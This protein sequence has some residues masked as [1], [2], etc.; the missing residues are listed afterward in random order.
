MLG[1]FSSEWVK[2][3]RRAMLLWGL[4][5][6]LFFALLA[7]IFTIERAVRTPQL[8]GGGHGVR[9]TFAVLEQPDGLTHGIVDI[10]GL[11]G[12]VALCLFAGAFATEYS[13]GTMR[14]LLV[15]E[16]RRSRLLAG[17]FLALAAFIT[18]AVVLEIVVSSAVAFALAPGRGISTAAWTSSAGL[19]DLGQATLHVF[20][21]SVGYGLLGAAFGILLRSPGVAIGTAVAYILPGEAIIVGAIWGNG[22]R[23]LPGQLLDALAHGGNDNSSY[24]HALVVLA[25][26]MAA[27][28]AGSLWLFRRRDA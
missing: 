5:G 22:D 27:L 18:I 26:Y 7:T 13:Q 2:L 10:S 11:I 15:R 4:G 6:G 19:D 20:L 9:V 3:R 16:P 23:W 28:A 1:A 25:I 24:S 21:A 14:N 12:I 8:F 17:K